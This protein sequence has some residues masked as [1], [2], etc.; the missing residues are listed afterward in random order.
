MPG[1]NT[2]HIIKKPNQM[3]FNVVMHTHA[4]SQSYPETTYF[5]N[6]PAGKRVSG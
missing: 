1:N 2:V 4:M 6:L 3:I 5:D